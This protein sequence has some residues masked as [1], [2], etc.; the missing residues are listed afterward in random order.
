MG[1]FPSAA[2]CSVWRNDVHVVYPVHPNP[3][4]QA[5]VN[6]NLRHVPNIRLIEPLEYV[7]FVDAMRKAY[8][9]LTDSGGVQEEGPSLGKP[10]LVMRDKTER[11]EAVDAG[12]AR[13]VGTDEDTIVA[14]TVRLLDDPEEYAKRARIH[15]PYG[16]GQASARIRDVLIARVSQR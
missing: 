14:E 9:L 10:V 5:V 1:L 15:N 11:V 4:V 13:L 12:S 6:Q 2:P 8:I 16:D 7:A 3:N